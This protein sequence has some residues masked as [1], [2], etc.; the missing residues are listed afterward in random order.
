MKT[1]SDPR[2]LYRQKIVQE[3]FAWDAHLKAGDH[4]LKSRDEKLIAIEKNISA[5]DAIIKEIAPEWEI[6]KINN[7]DLAILRL[8][9]FELNIEAT[10]PSKAVIDEAVELAKEFGSETSPGFINGALGQAF[11][12]P[13]RIKKIICDKLG[14]EIDKLLPEANL[15]G[16]LNANDLEIQDLFAYLEKDYNLKLPPE[17]SNST[18]SELLEYIREQNE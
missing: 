9:V 15:A 6:D 3:L 2:H 4:K 11:V 13:S 10:E 5:I 14:V 8:A 1:A 18:V 12:H 7:V 16:D 17:M